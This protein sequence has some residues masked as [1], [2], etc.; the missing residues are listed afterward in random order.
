MATPR[1]FT[2]ALQA[3][4]ECPAAMQRA[5]GRREGQA[6]GASACLIQGGLGVHGAEDAQ[7]VVQR[8]EAR[9][10]ELRRHMVQL[11]I[12]FLPVHAAL[13]LAKGGGQ[14]LPR[15][16]RAASSGRA[17]RAQLVGEV[18]LKA[19]RHR[20]RRLTGNVKAR[21]SAAG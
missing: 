17:R 7:H 20:T 4:A 5:H 19:D 14:R 11:L 6:C 10:L 12:E 21:A 16:V 8:V 2:P 9:V 18:V 1:L 3:P 13:A 15:R